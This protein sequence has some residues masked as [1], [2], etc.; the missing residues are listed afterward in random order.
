MD[1][2]AGLRVVADT[3]RYRVARNNDLIVIVL[4]GDIDDALSDEWRGVVQAC[5][6]SEGIPPFGYV[7][8][9]AAIPISTL[10]ARMRSA[11]FLR[12]NAMQ[13][14]SVAMIVSDKTSFMIRTVLRV[15]GLGNVHFVEAKD[16][17]V[18][19]ARLKA[20]EDLGVASA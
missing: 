8:T 14:K 13:M 17:D 5:F 6:D 1:P 7:D 11:A 12:R 18:A 20:G 16:A 2:L 3:E 10:P 15:A 9:R 19:F 4:R